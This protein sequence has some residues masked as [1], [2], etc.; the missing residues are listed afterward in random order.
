[1]NLKE[2]I[3]SDKSRRKELWIKKHHPAEYVEIVNYP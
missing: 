1:M 3:L 2:E